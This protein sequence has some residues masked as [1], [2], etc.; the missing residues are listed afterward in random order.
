MPL[1]LPGGYAD[2][3]LHH[4]RHCQECQLA[5]RDPSFPRCARG[6]QLIELTLKERHG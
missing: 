5:R 3:L 1:P 2:E 6:R 4:L